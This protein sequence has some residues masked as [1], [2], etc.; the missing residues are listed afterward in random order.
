M[1][2]SHRKGV[3]IEVH[4]VSGR[5]N[6]S[7]WR[8]RLYLRAVHLSG[9]HFMIP[10][11]RMTNS[12]AAE[13]ISVCLFCGLI[14]QTALAAEAGRREIISEPGQTPLRFHVTGSVPPPADQVAALYAARRMIRSLIGELAALGVMIGSGFLVT[15]LLLSGFSVAM[16]VFFAVDIGAL[17]LWLIS[18]FSLRRASADFK[19]ARSLG[20]AEGKPAVRKDDQPKAPGDSNSKGL[21]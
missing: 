10:C 20:A 18:F 6:V 15:L 14:A 5:I 13:A 8:D 19:A 11:H 4:R 7:H 17:T 16:P 12:G 2:D 9:R 1:P 3:D 21:E